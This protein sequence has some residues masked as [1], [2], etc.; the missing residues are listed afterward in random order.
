MKYPT[1]PLQLKIKFFGTQKGEQSLQALPI[2]WID[3]HF[4]ASQKELSRVYKL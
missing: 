1:I 2:R 3:M 4:V